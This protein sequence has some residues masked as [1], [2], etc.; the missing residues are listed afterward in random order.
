MK[1]RVFYTELAY[2]FGLLFIALGVALMEKSDFGVSMVVAPAY[3][4]YRWINPHWGFFSFGM[5]E[6]CFQALLLVA[7]SLA[8][9][10][11]RLSYLLS[12]ATAFVYGL[13]LDLFMLL[14]AFLPAS[15]FWQRA[16]LYLFGLLACALGVALMFHTYI[17]PE[18][19]ELVVKEVSARFG[20]EISRFKTFYDLSSCALAVVLSFIAFG[21]GSFVGVRLGTVLCALVNGWTIGRF[22]ALLEKKFTFADRLPW[23]PFFEGR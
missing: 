22:S 14:A 9:R 13:I 1:K 23:R 10:R 18:V 17:S 11:F 5:A 16:L 2:V 8:L 19:Y 4:L 3:V 21:F 6:Y 15:M 7:M 12:F 20:L